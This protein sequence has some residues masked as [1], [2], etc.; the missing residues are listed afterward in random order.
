[1]YKY[2]FLVFICV[3]KLNAYD[4][5]IYE[6]LRET[7]GAYYMRFF[8][9]GSG[10]LRIRNVSFDGV[11]TYSDAT[12]GVLYSILNNIRI[13][14][15]TS[16]LVYMSNDEFIHAFRSDNLF[17]NDLY[18][19]ITNEMLNY[20]YNENNFNNSN[21]VVYEDYELLYDREGYAVESI[22][23]G[24]WKGL[25]EDPSLSGYLYNANGELA[26]VNGQEVNFFDRLSEKIGFNHIFKSAVLFVDMVWFLSA[27][28]ALAVFFFG[29]RYVS[30]AIDS[31]CRRRNI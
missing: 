8:N 27:V 18:L 3:I 2:I 30:G 31:W 16:T 15:S 5:L 11:I 13:S 29:V 12:G 4:Y 6:R 9:D 19:T 22:V 26:Y 28:F 14:S 21:Y 10:S 23:N 20:F 17:L 7:T 1:M 24:V 25:Y